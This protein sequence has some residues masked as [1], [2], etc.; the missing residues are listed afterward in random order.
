MNAEEHRSLGNRFGI[1]GFPTLKYFGRGK[2]VD[3]PAD[4]QG[5]RSMTEILAYINKSLEA[6]AG[7]ARVEV[8]DALALRFR[9][10]DPAAVLEEARAQA[11][12]LAGDDAAHAP[13]YIKFMEKAIAKGGGALEHELVRLKTLVDGG[14]ASGAKVRPDRD[15]GKLRTLAGLARMCNQLFRLALCCSWTR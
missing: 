8:M 11:A 7:F 5:G 1:R 12:A 3:E 4:Y 6:D 10:E 2:P 9:T 14:K 15:A 13:M